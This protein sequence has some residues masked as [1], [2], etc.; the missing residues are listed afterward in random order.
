MNPNDSLKSF[1]QIGQNSS[2]VL[3][4]NFS[5]EMGK[6]KPKILK[7]L[8]AL[9]Q[10]FIPNKKSTASSIRKTEMKHMKNRSMDIT[11]PQYYITFNK[12]S[13]NGNQKFINQ[14]AMI[15]NINKEIEVNLQQNNITN[16]K[17][18]GTKSR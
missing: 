17:V 13:N 8:N 18:L 4:Q 6:A 9:Y 11:N 12:D 15:N 3:G 7:N 10:V 16:G 14:N 2:Q 1:L 5:I